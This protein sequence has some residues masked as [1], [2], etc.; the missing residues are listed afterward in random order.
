MFDCFCYIHST[1]IVCTV[2]GYGVNG[3]DPEMDGVIE[4]CNEAIVPIYNPKQK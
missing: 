3:L 2:L 1:G 4:A